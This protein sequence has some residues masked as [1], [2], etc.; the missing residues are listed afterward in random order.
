MSKYKFSQK[1]SKDGVNIK[2]AHYLIVRE[3]FD[4]IMHTQ[5][6]NLMQ[7]EILGIK[8]LDWKLGVMFWFLRVIFELPLARARPQS[9]LWCRGP[10]DYR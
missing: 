1:N 10:V 4:C 8:G 3:M 7:Y 5:V 2:T 6:F 9:I